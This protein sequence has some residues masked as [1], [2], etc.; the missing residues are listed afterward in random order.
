MFKPWLFSSHQTDWITTARCLLCLAF[1]YAKEDSPMKLLEAVCSCL[2]LLKSSIA[3]SVLFVYI[4]YIAC[5]SIRLRCLSLSIPFSFILMVFAFVAFAYC[6]NEKRWYTVFI[7][8]TICICT[9]AH[10]SYTR[11][12]ILDLQRSLCRLRFIN[13]HLLDCCIRICL[14]N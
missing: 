2:R 4:V 7:L 10:S 3:T 12:R 1:L 14:L 6:F 9:L 5:C 8:V 13:L 11:V